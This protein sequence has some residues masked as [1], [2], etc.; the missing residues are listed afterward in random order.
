M[1]SAIVNDRKIIKYTK[2]SRRNRCHFCESRQAVKY[3]VRLTE[4][5]RNIF[6][7]AKKNVYCCEKCARN[8][9]YKNAK[10][11]DPYFHKK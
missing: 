6:S 8:F 10:S 3:L 1:S 7:I 5:D 4:N 9:V 2:E 11:C